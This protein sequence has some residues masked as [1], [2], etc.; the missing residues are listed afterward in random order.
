MASSS[1]IPKK[2]LR[3]DAGQAGALTERVRELLKGQGFID[4]RDKKRVM[5]KLNNVIKRLSTNEIRLLHAILK[6]EK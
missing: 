4:N 5:P 3:T 1:P 2:Q 6:K